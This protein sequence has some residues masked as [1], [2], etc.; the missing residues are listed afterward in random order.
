MKQNAYVPEGRNERGRVATPTSFSIFDSYDMKSLQSTF[1][2]GIFTCFKM[3][4][5]TVL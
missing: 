2:H 3:A 1:G 5:S 4:V